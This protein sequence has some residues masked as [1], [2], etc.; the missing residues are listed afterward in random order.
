MPLP[1]TPILDVPNL[2]A[3]AGVLTAILAAI[4]AARSATAAHR[5]AVS[6]EAAAAEVKT[7]TAIAK[8]AVS[9]ARSQNRIAMHN[10]RLRIYKA[11]LAFQSELSAHGLQ[12][13]EQ[14]LW[15][16]WEHLRIAEFYFS[17]TIAT[18]LND[19]VEIALKL[20]TSRSLWTDEAAVSADEKS[21]LVKNSCDLLSELRKRT[22][23]VD[24]A[25]RQELSLITN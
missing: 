12:Y 9:E 5:Q 25:L 14:E 11:M 2:L 6:A 23:A 19:I 21:K 3:G 20:Q 22:K 4:I 8:E 7:Q 24:S 10:E 16:L 1:E 17:T 18:E 15:V 13:K